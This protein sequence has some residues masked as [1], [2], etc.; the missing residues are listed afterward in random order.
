MTTFD[1]PQGKN[2]NIVGKGEKGGKQ[3]FLLFLLF[4]VFHERQ[5]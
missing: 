4:F 5:I 3:H 2:E 1:A